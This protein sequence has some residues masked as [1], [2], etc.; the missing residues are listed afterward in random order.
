MS[1]RIRFHLDENVD[2]VVALSLRQI[3][4]DVTTSRQANLLSK[5]DMA[6]IEFANAERR[7]I[8]THDDDFLILDSQGVEHYGI[9]YSQK[10]IRS[11]GYLIRMIT[12][13]YEVATLDEM[14]S[15]VE[16]F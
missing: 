4:I 7:V 16:Y 5:S 15:R 14:R 1:E 12:L 10:N 6:Q 2:P 3:G 11:V 9:I 8:V 13:L